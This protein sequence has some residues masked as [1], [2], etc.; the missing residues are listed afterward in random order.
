MTRTAI[1]PGIYEHYKGKRYF[2]L[3]LSRN[4][5]SGEVC[6]VYRPLYETDWPQLAHRNAD[7]FFEQVEV[8]GRPMPRFHLIEPGT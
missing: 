7:M 6:V 1:T 8:D 3:G 2:V 4:T 5:K